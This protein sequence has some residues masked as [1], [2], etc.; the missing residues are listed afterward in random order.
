MNNK[1]MPHVG[2]MGQTTGDNSSGQR[3]C[4][5]HTTPIRAQRQPLFG[6][7]GKV[8]AWVTHDGALCKALDGSKHFLRQPAGIAFDRAIL[9]Q[10][11]DL[12]AVRVWVKDRETGAT[13]RAT[14]ETF[15]QHG[16]RLNRGF[17]DQLCLPFSFWQT[18]Q[19]GE[20]RQ[21]SLL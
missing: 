3:R 2:G 4:L 7:N 15:L 11:Q 10:A 14:M 6:A 8:C 20:P 21:L 12:G 16:M 5:P 9:Q 18:Q 17:G 19:P 13:Y 1:Q